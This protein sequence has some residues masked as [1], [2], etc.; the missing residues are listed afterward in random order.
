VQRLDLQA[1]TLYAELLQRV[2]SDT[3]A[4]SVAKLGRSFVSKK[5]GTK[6]YWYL[7]HRQASG[8]KQTYLGP[9]T[10]E[11]L[12]V[13]ESTRAAGKSLEPDLTRRK[14]LCAAIRAMGFPAWPRPLVATLET[15]ANAGVFHLGAILIGTPAYVTCMIAMGYRSDIGHTLTGDIDLQIRRT[16]EAS[17][18]DAAPIDVSTALERVKLGFFPLPGL[19]PRNPS[20]MFKVRDGDLMVQFL[21]ADEAGS[22]KPIYVEQLGTAAQPMPYMDYLTEGPMKAVLPFD[23][24]ILVNVPNPARL[25][26]HKQIVARN[27]PQHERGKARKDI[28]Q[29]AD[30]ITAL[31]E[32][33]REALEGSFLDA[34]QRGED[35]AAKLV[36][37][38]VRLKG[39]R[40]DAFELIVPILEKNLSDQHQ[41]EVLQGG[42]SSRRRLPL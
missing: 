40:P 28:E 27:R 38:L 7:Q 35:W 6:T 10:P 36:G 3:I 41:T 39:Q 32:S 19:D 15:L 25:A 29:A 26:W 8:M 17:M 14:E 31:L 33:D 23:T 12:Q 30:L 21:T 37:G 42:A 11:L 13:I 4:S 34:Y 18:P 16:S 5:I 22:D 2:L 9:E 24:G 20:S 1:Q